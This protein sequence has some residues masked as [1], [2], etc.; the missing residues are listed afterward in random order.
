MRIAAIVCYITVGSEVVGNKGTC[1]TRSKIIAAR[2]AL[3]EN[4]HLSDV[5]TVSV[6]ISNSVTPVQ[7]QSIRRFRRTTVRAFISAVL[8]LVTSLAVLA[9]DNQGSATLR[10]H[11]NVVSMVN[12]SEVLQK[13]GDLQLSPTS[14]VRVMN[15]RRSDWF[16][17]WATNRGESPNATGA[18]TTE[19]ITTVI[20]PR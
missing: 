15:N 10:I 11:I 2:R 18:A 3:A 9:A 4:L 13:T 19:L 6:P 7:G 14:E 17:Q 8:C 1:L 16:P 5:P 20:V 12:A